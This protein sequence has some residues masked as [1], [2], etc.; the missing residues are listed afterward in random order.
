MF[1]RKR[2]KSYRRAQEAVQSARFRTLVLNTAEW[3]ETGPWSTSE[4]ALMRARREMPI[5][6]SAAAQLSS[7]CKKIRRRGA[8]ISDLSPAQ[9]HRLRIQVKKARYAAD[10][11]S[12]VYRGKKSA[13]QCEKI[14][15]SLMQLQNLLGGINDIVTHK[16]LFA[17]IVAS[18][19][20]GLT[21]EQNRHRAF[22]AGLIIGDQ[23]AQIQKLHDRARKAYSR[24]DNAKAFWKLP[25]RRSAAL[26]QVPSTRDT[27][28]TAPAPVAK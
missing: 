26:P 22:A 6:S 19:A 15:S 16:A 8:K 4:D 17:D 27:L 11:F 25:R 7:R 18:P 21:G 13:K 24:F 3:V 14:R 23:Q 28:A 9:L 10:F 20:P 5:E 1:T 12:G 2:L